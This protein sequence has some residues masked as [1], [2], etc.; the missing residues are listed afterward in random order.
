MRASRPRRAAVNRLG[1]VLAWA[2]LAPAAPSFAA[3]WVPQDDSVVLETLPDPRAPEMRE[4]AGLSAARARAPGELEPALAL[5]R[6]ALELGR[7]SGDPRLVGRA[8]AA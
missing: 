1:A 5:A 8:E 6:R 4:L 7:R 3:P 2:V